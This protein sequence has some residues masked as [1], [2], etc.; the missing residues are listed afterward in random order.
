MA[1]LSR[2]DMLKS[3][4]IGAAVVAVPVDVLAGSQSAEAAAPVN[5]LACDWSESELADRRRVLDAGL[6]EDEA[7]AWLLVARAGAQ[8]FALPVLHPSI[9]PEIAVALHELQSKLLMRPTYRKYVQGFPAAD[10]STSY[11]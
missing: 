2:R 6:T 1:S 8:L 5:Q 3:A 7:T 9:N 4:A 10:Q 11:R